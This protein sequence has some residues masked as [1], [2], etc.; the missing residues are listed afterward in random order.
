MGQ[1]FRNRTKAVGI[2]FS[3]IGYVVVCY[4][5]GD[6]NVLSNECTLVKVEEGE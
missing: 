3:V 5:G 2:G 4:G 1:T 6:H